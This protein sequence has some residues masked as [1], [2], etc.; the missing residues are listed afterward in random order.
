MAVSASLF[1]ALSRQARRA[2][3]QLER[4]TIAAMQLV[5]GTVVDGKVVIEGAPLEEGAVVAVLARGADEPFTLSEQQENEL[6]AAMEEI[7]RGDFVTVDE[8]L[9]S[10]RKYG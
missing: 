4:S 7:E 9:E 3:A 5:T 1:R 10:L 2:A 6:L 8:L